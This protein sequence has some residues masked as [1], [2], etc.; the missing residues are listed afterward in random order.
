MWPVVMAY[1]S[2]SAARAGAAFVSGLRCCD[3]PSA[4]QVRL[5]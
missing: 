2:M 1:I 3:E 4:R 5:T